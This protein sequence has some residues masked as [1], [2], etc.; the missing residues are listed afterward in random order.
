MKGNIQTCLIEGLGKDL[1]KTISCI[2]K[3]VSDT[4]IL[5]L[6]YQHVIYV[7]NSLLDNDNTL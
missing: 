3:H 6:I 5:P 1:S 7:E 4:A 2:N